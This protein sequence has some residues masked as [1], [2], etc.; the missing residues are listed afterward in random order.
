[1]NRTQT[2]TVIGVV[3]LAGVVSSGFPIV[4]AQEGHLGVQDISVSDVD[5]GVESAEQS[6]VINSQSHET[7]GS[8][9]IGI[10]TTALPEGV[11]VTDASVDA[12]WNARVVTTGDD[13]T[14]IEVEWQNPGESDEIVLTLD[15]DTSEITYAES[16]YAIE[17]TGFT[18][19]R[20]FQIGTDPEDGS[21]DEEQDTTNGQ[22]DADD[23]Q[24]SLDDGEGVVYVAVEDPNG[25]RLPAADV[26]AWARQ[27]IS[28]Y[29]GSVQQ[30]NPIRLQLDAGTYDL[31]ADASG[32]APGAI[33]D[34]EVS[35]GEREDPYVIRVQQGGTVNG[36]VQDS[37]GNPVEGVTVEFEAADGTVVLAHTDSTGAYSIEL[38][39]DVYSVRAFDA[40][41]VSEET[42]IVTVESPDDTVTADFELRAPEVRE[43][44]IEHVAGAEPDMAAIDV[45]TT[46][47][48]GLVF[49]EIG[50]EAV[51]DTA[52]EA[53]APQD[54]SEYGVDETTVF[55]ITLIVD[56]FDPDSLIATAGDAEWDVTSAGGETVQLTVRTSAADLALI[57]EV[58]RGPVTSDNEIQWPSGRDDI[59]D[60]NARVVQLAFIETPG[61]NP[62][63]QR[64]VRGMSVATNAQVFGFPRIDGGELSVYLAA[65]GEGVDGSNH[66]GYYHVF[67]PDSLLD[68]WDVEDPESDLE[69]M[70]QEDDESFDVETTDGGVYV[71]IDPITYSDGTVVVRSTEYEAGMFDQLP[72]WWQLK[73]MMEEVLVTV[74]V[75]WERLGIMLS[76]FRYVIPISGLVL[77]G[78]LIGT[79]IH[80]RR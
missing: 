50:S 14:E 38:V 59:A 8:E 62:D 39:P 2:L 34:V 63:E 33:S 11:S 23:Q 61:L 54:L 73:L 17:A 13:R 36:V 72:S 20:S 71:A 44:S 66:E 42:R 40:T 58:Y 60:S 3:I 18:G 27:G 56:R 67:L 80:R 65:P 51:G 64:T 52:E 28:T 5:A 69:A 48:G 77:L 45:Q 70:W 53:F 12:N 21:E 68:E 79:L 16:E 49:V 35:E 76:A 25:D 74:H 29:R 30:E 37:N 6:I 15:L 43:T 31:F 55:E 75:Q 4:A 46:E 9:T 24:P 57:D 32:Y 26:D 19:V 41:R 10:D 7:G 1:M 22:G 78:A 47:Q